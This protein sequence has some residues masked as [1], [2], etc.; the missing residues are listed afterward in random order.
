MLTMGECVRAYNIIAWLRRHYSNQH[1]DP[2][3][4]T[5]EYSLKAECL[6]DSAHILYGKNH[7]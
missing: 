4:P 3:A 2:R 5:A 1:S 6:L 7:L